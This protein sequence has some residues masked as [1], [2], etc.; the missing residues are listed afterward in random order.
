MSFQL[1]EFGTF[2]N[3]DSF[4]SVM[5]KGAGVVDYLENALF[6]F[7]DFEACCRCR[8]KK[9]APNLKGCF[10]SLQKTGEVFPVQKDALFWI[11][12]IP[13]RIRERMAEI[14][15]V[16]SGGWKAQ[17]V[18]FKMRQAAQFGGKMDLLAQSLKERL[19]G[20][21]RVALFAGGKADAF[22]RTLSDFD[23]LAP[24]LDRGEGVFVT[25]E[26][27][28]YGFE[29]PQ[30]KT[31]FLG[32]WDIFGKIKKKGAKPPHFKKT[33]EELFAELKPGDY[34]VHEVHGRGRYLGLKRC[35]PR[36]VLR[37]I[38]R[39]NIKTGT[40]C[41]FP[42]HRSTVCR[43][44]SAAR[45]ARPRFPNWVAGNGRTQKTGYANRSPSWRSTWWTVRQPL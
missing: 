14:A 37:N 12:R 19:K 27:L 39:S 41:T 35:R 40:S 10:A 21:Y 11:L 30:K 31:Y 33:T 32:E 3:A 23:L 44:I 18:D 4:L 29:I 8:R 15:P 38:W 26:V 7:D 6:V 36:A 17:P 22:S 5:V 20:G 1:L 43:N 25:R 42:P 45:T 9:T 24:V 16:A 34:V 13:R 28:D 2:E